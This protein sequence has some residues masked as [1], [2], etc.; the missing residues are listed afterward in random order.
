MRNADARDFGVGLFVA[1]G[2][3]AI[4]YLSIQVGGVSYRGAGGLTLYATFDD[5]GGLSMRSPV[6]IGGVKVGQVRTIE[7]TED[8]RARVGLEL[9][10]RLELPMDTVAAIRTSGLL[11]DQFIALEPGGLDEMLRSGEELGFTESAVNLEKL[12]GTL[13]HGTRLN[14]SP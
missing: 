9:D 12:V 2:I 6:E 4:G 5:V 14:E 10:A 3:L 8:L 11:G 13:V 1:A 7:L